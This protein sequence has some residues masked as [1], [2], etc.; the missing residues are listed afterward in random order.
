[1]GKNNEKCPRLAFM[2]SGNGS[3]AKAIVNACERGT[4]DANPV[5]IVSNRVSAKAL[6]WGKKYGL[7]SVV[8]TNE[9]DQLKIL[10]DNDIDWVILSGYLSIIGSDILNGFKVINIHP[11]LLPRHGGRGMYG[12]RVHEAVIASGDSITG[13]TVHMVSDEI[14]QGKILGQST[15]EVYESDTP[16][17]LSER[18]LDVEHKLFPKVLSSILL[19][20]P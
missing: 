13:A 6:E 15:I 2:C 20:L 19:T 1:M 11:S 7:P 5:L 4:L 14:D 17:S 12:M 10:R 8:I 16:H 18:V 9:K 3:N